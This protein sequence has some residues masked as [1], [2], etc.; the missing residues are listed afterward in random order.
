MEVDLEYPHQLHDTHS[1]LPL[2]PEH[3][4]VTPDMLSDY[5][6]TDTSFHGHIALT[7]NLYNKMKYV[8]YVRNLQLYTQL[9]MKVLKIHRV[10]AFDR[11][12]YLA[13]YILFNTEKHQQARSEVSA[14]LNGTLTSNL[15]FQL[16]TRAG[17][18]LLGTPK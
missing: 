12:A 2:A 11:K 10:L 18:Q 17:C 3:L 6:N 7:P 13:P 16:D 1:D 15:R 9:G 8:L 14:G 5:S 4:K